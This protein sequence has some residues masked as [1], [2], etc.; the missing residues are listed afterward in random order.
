MTVWEARD[1]P[2]LT[3]L[4]TSDDPALREGFL[5]IGDSVDDVLGI[6]L[7][8]GQVH[9]AILTLQDAGYVEAELSYSGGPTAVLGLG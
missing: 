3:A 8:A 2:V 4:A 5:R 6:D 1:L 9:D 7:S